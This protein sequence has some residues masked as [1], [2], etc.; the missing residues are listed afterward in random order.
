[1]QCGNEVRRWLFSSC[2]SMVQILCSQM[3]DP[4]LAGQMVAADAAQPTAACSQS[5]SRTQ[6]PD[7]ACFHFQPFHP[8]SAGE[9]PGCSLCALAPP[10]S[11]RAVVASGLIQVQIWSAARCRVLGGATRCVAGVA[12]LLLRH[13]KPFLPSQFLCTFFP[14]QL[15]APVCVACTYMNFAFSRTTDILEHSAVLRRWSG[16]FCDPA[17]APTSRAVQTRK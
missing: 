10:A 11:P 7:P 17:T 4:F 5:S 9:L 1:M 2:G 6:G 15:R 12:H 8:T 3:L 16:G 14:R 13:P